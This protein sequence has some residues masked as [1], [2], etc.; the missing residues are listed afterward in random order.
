MITTLGVVEKS[1]HGPTKAR[2]QR[3]FDDAERLTAECLLDSPE[4]Y[5][6]EELSV[7]VAIV[8]NWEKTGHLTM[9]EKNDWL[10]SLFSVFGSVITFASSESQYENV[11][12]HSDAKSELWKFTRIEIQDSGRALRWEIVKKW[13]SI[14]GVPTEKEDEVARHV[15]TALHYIELAVEAGLAKAYPPMILLMLQTLELKRPLNATTSSFIHLYDNLISNSLTRVHDQKVDPDKKKAAC[16]AIAWEFYR[17]GKSETS[18]DSALKIISELSASSMVTIS[19]EAVLGELNQG[20]I[21]SISGS[22]IRFRYSYC[23]YYFVASHLSGL[24]D[25]QETIQEIERMANELYNEDRSNILLYLSYLNRDQRI[26]NAILTRAREMFSQ[27]EIVDFDEYGSAICSGFQKS[28]LTLPDGD[29]DDAQRSYHEMQDRMQRE[30][31]KSEA[32][33]EKSSQ[34]GRISVAQKTSSGTDKTLEIKI[35]GTNAEEIDVI[36]SL[37]SA[38]KTIQILGQLIRNMPGTMPG[39]TKVTITEE[40]YRLGMRMLSC[41]KELFIVCKN[42]IIEYIKSEDVFECR[43]KAKDDNEAKERVA[44][45]F[46]LIPQSISFNVIKQVSDSVGASDY[47]AVYDKIIDEHKNIPS[48]VIIDASVRLDHAPSFPKTEVMNLG[49]ALSKNSYMYHTLRRLVFHRLS[50]HKIKRE[51]RQEV[52]QYFGIKAN[53]PKFLVTKKGDL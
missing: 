17:T 35:N 2:A 1:E 12:L 33:G 44:K 20:K 19:G 28:N 13:F 53:S 36:R 24:M 51:V 25:K 6:Q 34:S 4:R 39:D 21:I 16:Q 26:L 40:S 15:Q 41:I 10:R 31:S 22:S 8:D 42:E 38:H 14:G 7:K 52:C 37:N 46:G 47:M 45:I 29:V 32:K 49:N 27:Y 43:T 3:L 11:V 18:K 9:E 23:Y 48:F 50:L 5:L 30:F